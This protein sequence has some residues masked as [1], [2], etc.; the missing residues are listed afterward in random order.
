MDR[1][2]VGMIQRSQYLRFALKTAE[3]VWIMRETFRQDLDGHVAPEL[4]V[5]CL[6]ARIS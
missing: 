1:S 6:G 3:P 4:G 2:D 5:V